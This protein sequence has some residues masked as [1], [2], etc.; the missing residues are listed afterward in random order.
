MIYTAKCVKG[1]FTRYSM[2]TIHTILPET[3]QIEDFPL[4]LKRYPLNP[5]ICP[6]H[7]HALMRPKAQFEKGEL[8][9]LTPTSGNIHCLYANEDTVLVGV[10]TP[11]YSMTRQPNFYEMMSEDPVDQ[12]KVCIDILKKEG[13]T[14]ADLQ[15]CEIVKVKV[16]NKDFPTSK[17]VD[18]D[19][20]SLPGLVTVPEPDIQ[21]CVTLRPD[22][23][24]QINCFYL[25]KPHGDH[26]PM[27][28]LRRYSE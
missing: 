20:Y 18:L 11:N 8:M 5:N 28:K 26:T 6:S 22:K 2:D 1:K 17:I 13:A 23:S 21:K 14:N 3:M 9:N 25:N 12:C 10:D 24:G 4:K 15:G 27:I 19:C 16:N 7:Y